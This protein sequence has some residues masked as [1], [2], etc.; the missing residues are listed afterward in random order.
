MIVLHICVER[1]LQTAFNLFATFGLFLIENLLKI[2]E[3]HVVWRCFFNKKN[4]WRIKKTINTSRATTL[5]V[6]IWSIYAFVFLCTKSSSTYFR[7]IIKVF[8]S[9]RHDTDLENHTVV[10]WKMWFAGLYSTARYSL[11]FEQ[12]IDIINKYN[13][14]LNYTWWTCSKT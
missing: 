5:L 7:H 11:Y 14:T 2:P 1:A 4:R 8:T 12:Y 3:I 6:L 13:K 10:I 9:D